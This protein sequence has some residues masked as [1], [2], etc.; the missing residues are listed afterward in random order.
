MLFFDV[1]LEMPVELHKSG[2]V[3]ISLERDRPCVCSGRRA[4]AASSYRALKDRSGKECNVE[5]LVTVI[6]GI[7]LLQ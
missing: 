2:R 6:Q 3:A 1:D 7:L 5:R 4:T